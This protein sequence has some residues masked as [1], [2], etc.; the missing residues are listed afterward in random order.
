MDIKE[1]AV[2]TRSHFFAFISLSLLT[3]SQESTGKVTHDGEIFQ[4]HRRIE[5]FLRVTSTT[6]NSN[7]EKLSNYDVYKMKWTSLQITCTAMLAS[8]CMRQKSA[9][10]LVLWIFSHS[11]L[12]SSL[13]LQCLQELILLCVSSILF[14]AHTTYVHLPLPH[15]LLPL[16]FDSIPI[17]FPLSSTP[18]TWL[19]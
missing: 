5:S 17:P 7:K 1:G 13:I 15:T 10:C 14:H 16:H 18:Q 2:S 4:T 9:A 6:W 12:Q 3:C 19:P 8:T 11:C